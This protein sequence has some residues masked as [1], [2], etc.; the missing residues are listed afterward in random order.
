VALFRRAQGQRQ[1]GAAVGVAVGTVR[2]AVG[3]L[4]RRRADPVDGVQV[5]PDRAGH[6]HPQVALLK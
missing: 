2:G 6:G 1:R 5:F 4:A 3:D